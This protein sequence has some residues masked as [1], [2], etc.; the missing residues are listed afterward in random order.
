[1][2]VRYVLVPAHPI[3]RVAFEGALGVDEGDLRRLVV[4]QLGPTPRAAQAGSA[5][6]SA[7][8]RV[9]RSRLSAGRGDGAHRGD[10]RPRPRDAGLH[11]QRR[12]ARGHPGSAHHPCR[13]RRRRAVGRDPGS[14]ARHALR[15]GHRG[16]RA[17]ALDRPPARPRLLRGPRQPRRAV[18]ARRRRG[19]RH[20]DA[21]SAHPRGIRR[22]PARAKTIASAW[23]RFAP[24]RR[25][26]KIC[27]RTRRGRSRHSCKRQGYRD[28]RV[29][30]DRVPGD[31]DVVITF[32]I[33]R[34]PRYEVGGVRVAG[35]ASVPTAEIRDA[36]ARVARATPSPR[37]RSALGRGQ[38]ARRLSAPRLRRRRACRPARTSI[39]PERAA[40]DERRIDLVLEIV[41]GPRTV[42]ARAWLRGPHG[43][44]RA[45]ALRELAALRAGPA[46]LRGGRHQRRATASSWS[47][48]TAA[49][50]RSSCGPAVALAEND[51]AR[52]R[53]LHA[54][55]GAAGDR[56][57]RAHRRRRADQPRD[58]SARAAAAAR[59]SR[60]AMPTRSRA[61]RAWPRWACSAAS[62][63]RRS[64]H[65]GEPRRDVLVRVEESP[66]TTDRRRRRR[67][68][69]VPPA[70]DEAGAG[71]KS[72]SRWCRA[73]S[74]RSA[75]GTCGARTG[76]S[77][78]SRASACATATSA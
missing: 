4:D 24:R 72:A 43:A 44:D 8:A 1:M 11:G 18:P 63:S 70:T 58:D 75:G 47:T 78:C 27:S 67:G 38:R 53:P 74:S 2:L 5:T 29:D 31:N 17:A 7:E 45:E 55:R 3:D 42:V 41:E 23:C 35:N 48:A 50:T 19:Q 59:A 64:P 15:P 40:D 65:G 9:S 10:P 62:P 37:R 57:P 28:A 46:V 71:A 22:R 14:A 20:A 66:P 25:P 51:T 6:D 13:R 56:G 33:D 76:R 69:R 12:P 73:G 16:P 61:A 77:T 60:S 52:R 39:V 68:G 54:G 32:T 49:T 30:Y 36:A 34:G 26:T 21:G